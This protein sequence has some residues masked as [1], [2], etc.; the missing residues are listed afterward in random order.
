MNSNKIFKNEYIQRGEIMKI[1]KTKLEIAMARLKMNR[2]DLVKK[3]GMPAPT[4]KCLFQRKLQACYC[5]TDCR[6]TWRGCN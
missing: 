5:R 2:D 6:G 4:V 3:S 1:S